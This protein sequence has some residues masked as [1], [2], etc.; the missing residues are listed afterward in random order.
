[1][2]NTVLTYYECACKL[3]C[4]LSSQTVPVKCFLVSSSPLKALGSLAV[5]QVSCGSQHSIVLTQGKG[6]LVLRAKY[7]SVISMVIIDQ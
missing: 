3:L 4:C 1:M 2:K 7:S 5:A 6:G